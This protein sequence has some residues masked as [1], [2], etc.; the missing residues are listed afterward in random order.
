MEEK[1]DLSM[2]SEDKPGESVVFTDEFP[3]KTEKLT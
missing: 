1:C 3:T 2:Y